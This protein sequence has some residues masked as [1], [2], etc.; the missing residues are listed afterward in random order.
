MKKLFIMILI[1]TGVF[2]FAYSSNALADPVTLQWTSGCSSNW[3]F[4]MD[5]QGVS[6]SAGDFYSLDGIATATYSYP[7]RG[8]AI[9]DPVEDAY[10]VTLVFTSE[11]GETFTFGAALDTTT[12]SGPGTSQ[13]IAHGSVD[14]DCSG[15][16][17]VVP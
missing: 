2:I 5:I 13:R 1:A 17:A 12:A 15:T 4:S 6:T 8:G 16:L 11:S 7:V 14:S 10:M 9:Y 3:T